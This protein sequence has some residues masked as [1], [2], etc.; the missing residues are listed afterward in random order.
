MYFIHLVTAIGLLVIVVLPIDKMY[1][2]VEGVLRGVRW[3]KGFSP[4]VWGKLST[5]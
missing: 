3:G 5:K 4:V 1:R 2:I